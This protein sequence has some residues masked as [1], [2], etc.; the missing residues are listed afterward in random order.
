MDNAELHKGGSGQPILPATPVTLTGGKVC[1]PKCFQ[2]AF[3]GIAKL[4]PG[5]HGPESS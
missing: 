1:Q 4:F 2:N 3:C 5:E